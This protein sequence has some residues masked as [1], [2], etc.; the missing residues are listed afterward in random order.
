[1]TVAQE[2]REL[3]R[4]IILHGGWLRPENLVWMADLVR[5]G[6]VV[7]DTDYEGITVEATRKGVEYALSE[8]LVSE[9]DMRCFPRSGRALA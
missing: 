1:M 5:A 3:M 9:A 6:L 4:D 2:A 8:R 7:A